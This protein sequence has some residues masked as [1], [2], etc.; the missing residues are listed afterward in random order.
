MY[1]HKKNACRNNNIMNPA[2]ILYKKEIAKPN[3]IEVS[4]VYLKI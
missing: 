3:I 4:K 1:F 2:T